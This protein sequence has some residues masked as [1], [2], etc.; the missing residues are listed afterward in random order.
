M[1]GLRLDWNPGKFKAALTADLVANAEIVGEFVEAEARRRLLA[2]PDIEL[3]VRVVDG[4]RM[5]GRGANYRKYVATLLDNEVEQDGSNVEIRV[6]VRSGKGGSHHGL[7][8]E[9]GSRTNP[10]SP[11]LRPAVYENAA[12]IVLLLSGK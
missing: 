8:I 3:G 5:L 7:Y 6:G 11:F 9:M 2:L 4:Q 1:S 12:K 10:P